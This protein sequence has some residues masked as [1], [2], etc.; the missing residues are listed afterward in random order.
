MKKIKTKLIAVFLGVIALMLV[1]NVIFLALHFKILGDYRKITDNML[2]EYKVI[3]TTDRLIQTHYILV[4][5]ASAELLQEYDRLH[6]EIDGIFLQL[7][8]DI[9]YR[10]SRFMYRGLKNVIRNIVEVCDSSLEDILAGNVVKGL[11]IYAEVQRK[12]YF[13]KDNFASFILKELEYANILNNKYQKTHLLI[14]ASGMIFIV[15]L[16]FACV[17]FVFIFSK[18]LTDPLVRLSKLALDITGGNLSVKVENVLLEKKDEIGILA[19]SFNTMLANLKERIDRERNRAS[20]IKKQHSVLLE[21]SKAEF[22][23]LDVALRKITE[24]AA[25]TINVERVNVW[26]FDK[27]RTKI[28]C[29]GSYVLSE[30]KYETG[31]EILIKDCPRYFAALE[32]KRVIRVDDVATHEE[33]R[34]FK[35]TYFDK[36][37]IVSLLD[38]AI[39]SHGNTIGVICH[40]HVG[41][42]RIWSQEE[43]EFVSSIADRIALVMEGLERRRVEEE[44]QTTYDQLRKSQE[45]LVQAAKFKAIGQLASSVAHEV[46]NPLAIIMQSIDYLRN[47]VPA[48]QQEVIQVAADNI[49][50]ANTII[51][52][53]MDF[54]KAKE[55]NIKPENINSIIDDSLALT[56][57]S[58]LEEKVKVVKELSND[59]PKLLVDRQKIIQVFVNIFLNAMQAMLGEG[60]IFVRT[61]LSEFKRPQEF[62]GEQKDNHSSSVTKTVII[63]VEDEGVGISEENMNNIFQPFFTTKEAMTGIGLGLSVVREIITMH[64]GQIEI[65]SKLNQGT[66]VI[67]ALGVEGGA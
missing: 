21:F 49:K 67:I 12:N 25:A 14:L 33:T 57:Y 66:K 41:E 44:L 60:R 16:T 22:S 40:E 20:E 64:N 27:A 19:V 62:P 13:V 23:Y 11:E 6:K 48:Q 17:I 53:L 46:R 61:Y 34:E 37:G 65:K 38:A 2:L 59:L 29:S 42:N 9:V 7:D 36:F 43:F 28:I 4:K 58:N 52:T 15:F 56:R 24:V 18:K 54:S 50:R 51:G 3:A 30:N 31:G 47:R 32:D 26:F 39:R 55:L 10:E 35:I 5:S 8:K 1:L 63:E 45:E